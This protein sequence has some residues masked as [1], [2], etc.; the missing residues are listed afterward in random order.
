[1]ARTSVSFTVTSILA[2]AVI[3][4]LA[5]AFLIQR[6]GTK[7]LTKSVAEFR[8]FC[9]DS[10]VHNIGPDDL[11]TMINTLKYAGAE[12]VSLNGQRIVV[13][14]AIVLSGS[15]IILVNEEPINRVE[16]VPYELSVIGDQDTLFDYFS[17]L[18]AKNLK[19]D[20]KTVSIVR[21]TLRIPSYKGSIYLRMQY[22]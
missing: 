9:L 14:T 15:S 16:G 17:K 8:K 21:K 7:L 11:A 5:F 1:M 4:I 19:L 3:S 18:E 22:P 20:N 2:F 10:W 12:A 13:S 6:P